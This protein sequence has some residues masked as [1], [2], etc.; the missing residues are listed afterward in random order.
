MRTTINSDTLL[1]NKLRE[2]MVEVDLP[3]DKMI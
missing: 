2:A 3:K 1:L